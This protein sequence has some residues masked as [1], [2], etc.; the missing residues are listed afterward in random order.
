MINHSIFF[1]EFDG[2]VFAWAPKSVTGTD[3]AAVA[4]CAVANTMGRVSAAPDVVTSLWPWL[5]KTNT[6]IL[7]RFFVEKCP[8]S[9]RVRI[10]TDLAAQI[11]TTFRGGAVGTQIFMPISMLSWFVDEFHAISNDLFFN[12][13]LSIGL[14]IGEIEPGDWANVFEKI[15]YIKASSIIFAF[16]NDMADK[17]DFVG[18]IYEMLDSFDAGFNGD[19]YFA[20]MADFRM[21]QVWRL[22]KAMRPE[23]SSRV[24][25]FMRLGD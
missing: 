4:Q 24:G 21:Q 2:H 19:I 10:A 7:S 15:K 17:S 13:E 12:R 11:N 23:I 20:P 5:E 8:V 25:F 1:D 14:E 9:A 6:L 16:S 22:I 3:L 18:R